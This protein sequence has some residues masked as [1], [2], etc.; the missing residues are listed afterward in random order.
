[1]L[2][3]YVLILLYHEE[4]AYAGHAFD[5]TG[6]YEM[7]PRKEEEVYSNVKYRYV[8]GSP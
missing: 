7:T 4:Y 3:L 1:M 6:V 2:Y 8:I 5:D